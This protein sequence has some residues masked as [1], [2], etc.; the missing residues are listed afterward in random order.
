MVGDCVVCVSMH[1]CVYS[2]DYRYCTIVS[3]VSIYTSTLEYTLNLHVKCL[4]A[5]SQNGE[6]CISSFF[7]PEGTNHSFLGGGNER[8]QHRPSSMHH[9]EL[10]LIDQLAK[11]VHSQPQ[12]AYCAL[13][14]RLMSR[15]SYLM[16]VVPNL[17]DKLQPIEEALRFRLLPAITGRSNIS[18]AERLIF[19]LPVR[20]GR[21]G[22]LIPTEATAEQYRPSCS[23]TEPLVTLCT[24]QNTKPLPNT[25]TAQKELKGETE[26]TAERNNRR[27]QQ[28][29]RTHCD[30]HSKGS[31]ARL[32][33]R[34]V[35]LAHH[36][37]HQSTQVILAQAGFVYLIWMGPTG[38]PKPLLMWYS[39]QQHT[40][41]QLPQ[42][43]IVKYQAHHLR[44]DS[45]T[46]VTMFTKNT[47]DRM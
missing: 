39:I 17:G 35:Y 47:L 10:S 32:R 42:R 7:V 19:A 28:A 11:I 34:G 16:R 12:S 38:A 29:S 15:W 24:G 31:R 5:V 44:L 3:E 26:S 37:I 14:N 40:C 33:E 9:H 2:T 13:T 22:I 25:Y 20:D 41:L 43:S 23:I 21:L 45:P 18:D 6:S 1:A 8:F 27:H 30:L 46:F 4:V 36:P